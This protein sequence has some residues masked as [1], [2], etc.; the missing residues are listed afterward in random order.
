MLDIKPLALLA[1]VVNFAIFMWVINLFVFRP[2]RESL[3]KRREEI[4]GTYDTL[5]Q[6]E[7]A[8]AATRAE[9]DARLAGIEREI[10]QMKR[11]ALL[12]A[13]AQK[14]EI[15]REAQAAREVVLEKARITVENEILRELDKLRDHVTNLSIQA[16]Q[17]ILKKELDRERQ[18]EVVDRILKESESVTWRTK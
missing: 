17:A 18:L 6:Q 5:A 7:R 13:Q 4:K 11:Q 3:A 14:E 1:Q 16:A 2:I 8:I 9:L 10:A 15:L 12:D